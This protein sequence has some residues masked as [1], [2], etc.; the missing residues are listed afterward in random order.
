M[1]RTRLF[2]VASRTS[3]L[4]AILLDDIAPALQERHQQQEDA[5]AGSHGGGA[6]SFSSVAFPCALQ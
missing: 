6:G 2:Y 5:I 3:F 1:R 4:R